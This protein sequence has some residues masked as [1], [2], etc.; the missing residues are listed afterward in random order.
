MN[1]TPD[2]EQLWH[3]LYELACSQAHAGN[4]HLRDL[5][6]EMDVSLDDEEPKL[7]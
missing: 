4:R 5:M 1:P 7:N 2:Y 6:E 3:D